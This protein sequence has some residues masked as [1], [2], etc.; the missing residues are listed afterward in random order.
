MGGGCLRGFQAGFGV[1]GAGLEVLGCAG[2]RRFLDCLH[3]DL[4]LYRAKPIWS[5]AIDSTGPVQGLCWVCLCTVQVSVC[6]HI[7]TAID[8]AHVPVLTHIHI[9]RE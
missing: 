3:T 1:S 5:T 9:I 8:I 2:R 6:L 7:D 4:A